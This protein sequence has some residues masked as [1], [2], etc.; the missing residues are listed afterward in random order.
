MRVI[1]ELELRGCEAAGYR[2]S[3]EH[4]QHLCCRHLYGS[5][6]MLTAWPARAQVVVVLIGPHSGKAEDVHDKLLSAL[7]VEFSADERAKPSCCDEE[8][9]PPVD[10]DVADAISGAVA[11]SARRPRRLR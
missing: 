3:G 7:G 4:L 5:D 10:K 11:A 1:G 2:L 8:G 9:A 6:R